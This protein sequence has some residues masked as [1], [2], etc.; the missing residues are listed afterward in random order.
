MACQ[1]DVSELR[2]R[3]ETLGSAAVLAF[4]GEQHVAQLQFRRYER[5][6]RSPDG[7]WDPL[8]WGDFGDDA[9]EL[10]PES[11]SIFCYHVGQLDNSERRDKR[12]QGRGLGQALLDFLL[13]W[14]VDARLAAV[15]A[16]AT[17]SNRAVMAFMGGQPRAVYQERGFNVVASWI[18]RQLFDVVNEKGL[19]PE[20]TDVDE[21]AGIS[22]CVKF[23]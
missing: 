3:I 1:G 19:V 15:V 18:D 4:D 23:L 17:P 6:L 8:Y 5:T 21:S 20:G 2:A 12:Y 11:L 22:C 13:D 10:P 16:K 14:A 9:P 7:L